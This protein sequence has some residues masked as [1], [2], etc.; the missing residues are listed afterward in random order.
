[1]RQYQIPAYAR[2][3]PGNGG[4]TLQSCD[5]VLSKF[6][7]RRLQEA[8]VIPSSFRRPILLRAHSSSMDYKRS[9]QTISRALER[10]IAQKH[11]VIEWAIRPN[12]FGLV[13]VTQYGLK[14]SGIHA[15]QDGLDDVLIRYTRY[16]NYLCRKHNVPVQ[17]EPGM[18][19][20]GDN[21]G[22]FRI[23]ISLNLACAVPVLSGLSALSTH[24]QL[25]ALANELGSMDSV[26]S[27]T[28][29]WR[30]VQVH[31]APQD[32]YVQERAIPE[33]VFLF[34]P[35]AVGVLTTFSKRIRYG[36]AAFNPS[37]SLQP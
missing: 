37:T 17:I 6:C 15:S 35:Q 20:H 1:M 21:E 30:Y 25:Q 9:L 16:L 5:A 4:A 34:L 2:L 14:F 33:R 10:G 27:N 13:V 24:G 8:K 23:D 3:E 12:D 32:P 31:D 36:P 26:Y 18:A 7:V 28:N 22:M 19:P 29:L 11:P